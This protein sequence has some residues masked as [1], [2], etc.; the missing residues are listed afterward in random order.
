MDSPKERPKRYRRKAVRKSG[1]AQRKLGCPPKFDQLDIAKLI[2]DVAEG[3]PV[4]IAS[5]AAGIDP[6]TFYRWLDDRPEFAQALAAEKHRVILGALAGIRAGSKDNEWRNHAW[7]L[8]HVFKDYF[9]LPAPGVAFG[10]QQNFTITIEK[11]KEI[12]DQRARLLPEVNRMLGITNGQN[13]ESEP[14][15]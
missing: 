12:E 7:F 3:V 8:E 6:K 15:A 4:P 5:M 1:P 13:N 11:A 9:A 2:T 10:V 14:R